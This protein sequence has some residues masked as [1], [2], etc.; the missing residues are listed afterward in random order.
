MTVTDHSE[1]QRKP[2]GSLSLLA[3]C[4]ELQLRTWCMNIE[5]MMLA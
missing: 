4:L 1:V 3:S 5:Y 2:S